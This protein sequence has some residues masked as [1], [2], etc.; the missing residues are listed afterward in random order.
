MALTRL[1][2]DQ[3]ALNPVVEEG[4]EAPAEV[5]WNDFSKVPL[6]VVMAPNRDRTIISFHNRDGIYDDPTTAKLAVFE[7][8]DGSKVYQGLFPAY[9]LPNGKRAHFYFQVKAFP[10]HVIKLTDKTGCTT[11]ADRGTVENSSW[12]SSSLLIDVSCV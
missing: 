2:P 4:E 7:A 10:I 1:L 6:N 8:I 3:S 5:K 9:Q 11:V 12:L